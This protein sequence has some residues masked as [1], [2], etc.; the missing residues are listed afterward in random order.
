MMGHIL[1][2]FFCTIPFFQSQRMYLTAA[3]AGQVQQQQRRATV[4]NEAGVDIDV[5]WIHP[6]NKGIH[7]MTSE[8]QVIKSG[9]NMD[10]NSFAGHEFEI[11]EVPN[12]LGE[13]EGAADKT[14]RRVIFQVSDSDYQST[15]YCDITTC[16]Q[17]GPSVCRKNTL[18]IDE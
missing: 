4:A 13:C 1:V 14:C 12:A 17:F 10:V 15:S 3:A 18:C 2:V 6:G 8:G 9:S 7:K 5:Y 16:V 11:H